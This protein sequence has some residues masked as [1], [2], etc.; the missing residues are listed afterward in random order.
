[1][2]K[3]TEQSGSISAVDTGTIHIEQ[4]A[5]VTFKISSGAPLLTILPCV[6]HDLAIL[7]NLSSAPHLAVLR[8][9]VSALVVG[10]ALV[11]EGENAVF[12]SVSFAVTLTKTPEPGRTSASG[13]ERSTTWRIFW[14]GTGETT[15]ALVCGVV[16]RVATFG[17]L[18]GLGAAETGQ[19][20]H[21]SQTGSQK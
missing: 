10:L 2:G 3:K 7:I 18:A 15:P 19:A 5:L 21:C 14:L 6:P 17:G 13:V 16:T 12:S 1:L 9:L 4:E 20:R 11:L 8:V